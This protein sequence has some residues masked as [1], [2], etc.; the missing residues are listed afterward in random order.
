[1]LGQVVTDPKQLPSTYRVLAWCSDGK[2][3]VYKVTS[4]TD[5]HR[6]L[7]DLREAAA[8]E[9]DEYAP[10]MFKA[11]TDAVYAQLTVAKSFMDWAVPLL[12][13]W[14]LIQRVESPGNGGSRN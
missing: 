14:G 1:M 2:F 13:E 10:S 8:M 12:L 4:V 3:Y 11:M 5:E 6:V 7:S 9:L